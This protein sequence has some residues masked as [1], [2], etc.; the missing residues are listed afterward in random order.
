[1]IFFGLTAIKPEI[2]KRCQM[3]DRKIALNK[4]ELLRHVGIIFYEWQSTIIY[5]EKLG[6]QF[7]LCDCLIFMAFNSF[8]FS[9]NELSNRCRMHLLLLIRNMCASELSK[10][11]VEL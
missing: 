11:C 5:F 3:K 8:C 4:F 9:I 7:A 1:M 2:I 6:N 10:K